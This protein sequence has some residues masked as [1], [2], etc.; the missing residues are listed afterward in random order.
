MVYTRALNESSI[1][2]GHGKKHAWI[3]QLLV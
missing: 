2:C 3:Q 1:L